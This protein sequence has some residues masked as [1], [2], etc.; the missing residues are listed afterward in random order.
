MVTSCKSA[1][2]ALDFILGNL[3]E[4]QFTLLGSSLLSIN[5]SLSSCIVP[6]VF[7]PLLKRSNLYPQTLSNYRLI[8]NSAFML[9][10]RK[11]GYQLTHSPFIL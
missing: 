6:T 10:C 5:K 1:T 9:D 3:T 2:C 4:E 11:S 8:P 7:N